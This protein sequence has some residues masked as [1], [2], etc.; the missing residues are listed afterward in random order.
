MQYLVTAE[1][2]RS[3]E[4]YMIEKAGM[5]AAV[6][7]ERAA[8]SVR[9]R[10][11]EYCGSERVTGK[12][13]LVM[14]GAGNNGGD[15]L[16]LA[17][18]LADDGWQAEIWFVGDEEKCSELWR[19]QRNIV[20]CYLVCF[21]TK[22]K[23]DEYTILVDAL[24]GV[25]LSREITG[26]FAEA[27]EIF[28]RLD[29]R[30]F[31]L[32]LPSGVD[33]DTGRILGTAVKADETVS[34]GFCK[35]GLVLYP[36]CEQ[37]GKITVADIGISGSCLDGREPGMYALDGSVQALL[38]VRDR[39]GN[40]GTFG[41]VLLAAG[42]VNMAGAAVLAARAAYRMGAGM[43]KVITPGENR[44]ILQQAVPE[45]LIGTEA[46][47]ED[48]MKWAD[49]IAAGPGLGKSEFAARML[50]KILKESSLP[51][52]LDADGLNLAASHRR[53]RELLAAGGRQ[54]REIVLT[55]H[56]G[57]LARLAGKSIRE[58]KEDVAGCGS[59]LAMELQ[60]VV[61]AKDARTF[62][63]KPQGPVCVNL[64]G[65]S[66]LATAGSGDVLAGMI[67]G[68]MAQGM[69]AGPAACAGAYIHGKIGDA[70]SAE[71][72]EHACMAGDLV[73]PFGFFAA[74]ELKGKGKMSEGLSC[75]GEERNNG[76]TWNT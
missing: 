44:V 67:A 49:V 38:P 20:N 51:L 52:L 7:M 40:K 41:K 11:R 48:G 57:E 42:S 13:V 1:E 27:V 61:A 73:R 46:D 14:A 10:I 60:A 65:N 12:R 55:P 30:K 58:V 25:G 43:V 64:S 66:G 26:V 2:M 56:V 34:F 6:L 22:P 45:A 21:S 23:R 4:R 62:I 47:L 39:L 8:L 53:L 68:L 24:F 50:K 36:G 63:C 18:L 69:K 54:G 28:N 35:R 3:C 59:K 74:D 19:L 33:S 31:S 15:G 9:D 76:F 71:I 70:V 75:P 72:G 32:D 17:R 16:A 37:A 29:G 5:P